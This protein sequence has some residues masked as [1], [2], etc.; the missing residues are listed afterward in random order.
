MPMITPPRTFL[1]FLHSI[2]TKDASKCTIDFAEKGIWDPPQLLTGTPHLIKEPASVPA[3]SMTVPL[4]PTHI[5]ATPAW[6][7]EIPPIVTSSPKK[8]ANPHKDTGVDSA[9]V[10]SPTSSSGDVLI[11]PSLGQT[12]AHS[13]TADPGDRSTDTGVPRERPSLPISDTPADPTT[14]ANV[15]NS[16]AT[17][18]SRPLDE[19]SMGSGSIE[20]LDNSQAQNGNA[21]SPIITP[22]HG[23]AA[24]IVSMINQPLFYPQSDSDG[25]ADGNLDTSSGVTIIASPGTDDDPQRQD[26]GNPFADGPFS[27]ES[28]PGSS[29]PRQNV[30][31]P[32]QP[33]SQLTQAGGLNATRSSG[34]P[35]EGPLGFTNDVRGSSS[36][37]NFSWFWICMVAFPW[38]L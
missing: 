9:V 32:T 3:G 33:S 37:S 30:A 38:L 31:V 15:M 34:I 17:S 24:A 11:E 2:N 25:P 5:P 36:L 8:L 10:R 26:G 4:Q 18:L 29:D 6:T 16:P 13:E 22:A 35:A 12:L 27:F 28:A 1:D 19:I 7:Q 14:K 21:K 23:I 20:K